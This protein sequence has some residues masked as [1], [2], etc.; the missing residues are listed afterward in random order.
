M[1]GNISPAGGGIGAI[2]DAGVLRGPRRPDL[3]RDEVLA[4][5][6][7]ASAAARPDRPALTGPEGT[8]T[9]GEVNAASDAIARG[10]IR[11]GIGSR[12]IVGLW[13][14]RGQ[15]LLI[16]QIAITKAGAAWLPFDADIPV[17]RIA[18]CLRDSGAQTLLTSN[19]F[20]HRIAATGV[21]VI[22]ADALVDPS[23]DTEVNA[24]AI[25]L[26][27]DHPAYLIYTAGSH[28][29]FSLAAIRRRAQCTA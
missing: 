5:I 2:A 23:D 1:P 29:L 17:E 3:I 9:Y 19:E 21:R 16:A 12:S 6:F 4:D 8:Q 7:C 26:T 22:T 15:A 20:A 10:L 11:N 25:S 28:R 24:R 13:M 18:N 14:R 27:P